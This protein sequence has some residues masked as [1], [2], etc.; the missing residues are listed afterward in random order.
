MR[1]LVSATDALMRER[2]RRLAGPK[3]GHSQSALAW[4]DFRQATE[5]ARV[6]AADKLKWSSLFAGALSGV[7]SITEKL[8]RLG[9]RYR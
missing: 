1:C 4:A 9:W 7:L 2:P 8:A 3:G 5:V 6:L